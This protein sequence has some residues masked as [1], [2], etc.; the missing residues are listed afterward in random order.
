M[1]HKI[2]TLIIAFGVILA[3]IW[4]HQATIFQ[5]QVRENLSYWRSYAGPTLQLGDVII[6]KYLFKV[7]FKKPQLDISNQ[8]LE[9]IKENLQKND[10][11]ISKFIHN[12]LDTLSPIFRL[13]YRLA[14]RLVASYNPFWHELTLTSVGDAELNLQTATE[15]TVFI[16]PDQNGLNQGKIKI[17]LPAPGWLQKIRRGIFKDPVVMSFNSSCRNLKIVT[18][19]DHEA[20]YTQDYNLTKFSLNEDWVENKKYYTASVD[21]QVDNAY[22]SPTLAKIWTL[23]ECYVVA[24]KTNKHDIYKIHFEADEGIAFVNTLIGQFKPNQ[25]TDWSA[26][27]KTIPTF[28]VEGKS[29]HQ[30]HALAFSTDCQLDYQPSKNYLKATYDS[31]FQAHTIWPDYLQKLCDFYDEVICAFGQINTAFK[32]DSRPF[33]YSLLAN[34]K[35]KGEINTGFVLELQDIHSNTCQGQG[36]L[37]IGLKNSGIMIKGN[38]TPP[39]LL[40]VEVD[41]EDPELFLNK[42]YS[43]LL[44]SLEG[45]SHK[46][47]E[48]IL[49]G[50]KNNLI[51]N[52]HKLGVVKNEDKPHV[53][54]VPIQFNGDTQSLEIANQPVHHEFLDVIKMAISL[55]GHHDIFQDLKKL[56]PINP[57]M[58]PAGIP[59]Q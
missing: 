1:G 46:V 31:T 19:N 47:A 2:K 43:H 29:N 8:T 20:I 14:D 35:D 32:P 59:P 22:L 26:V 36:S 10:G 56:L 49:L 58:K 51:E 27:V 16:A 21:L 53:R 45:A 50:V 11:S 12:Q 18:A 9:K 7:E 55:L 4:H 52:I 44:N 57:K 23:L 3:V 54:T 41:F 34:L 33:W 6:S 48:I 5:R 38:Y 15:N 39:S 28:K 30:N 40:N 25:D 37:K 24:N 17:T 42:G 13:T